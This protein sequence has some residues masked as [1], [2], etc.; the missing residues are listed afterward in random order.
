MLRK[1]NLFTAITASA[2]LLI[3]GPGCL[4]DKLQDDGLTV[5]EANNSPSLIEFPGKPTGFNTYSSFS[6]VSLPIGNKDTTFDAVFVRL[7]SGEPA[8]QDIKVQLELVPVL[9][10]AYNDS[11]HGHAINIPANLVRVDPADWTVTIPA[12]QRQGALKMTLNPLDISNGQF[13]YGLRIKSSNNST[14]PISK[15]FENS[16]VVIG[17]RNKYDGRYNFRF[18]SIGWGAYGISDNVV[19]TWP[20]NV[21]MITTGPNTVYLRADEIGGDT[22]PAFTSAAD[23]TSFGA[24]QIEFNFDPVNNKLLSVKNLEP[25]DGRGR[26]FVLNPAI[27]TSRYDPDAKIIYAAYFMKQNGRPDQAF[28]DT[29]TWK[30]AR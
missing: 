26:A 30:A 15:N 13:A 2:F 11:V 23:L 4:K 12:G 10:Q 7:A 6:V 29:L 5:P 3:A 14:Y 28:Y 24:T 16:I 25:D 19:R 21:N 1:Y 20:S 17:V 22:H 27:T 9:L 8:P 18:N